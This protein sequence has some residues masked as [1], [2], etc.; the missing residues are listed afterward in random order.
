MRSSGDF[1]Y[2]NQDSLEPDVLADRAAEP[3]LGLEEFG[4][5]IKEG[6]VSKRIIEDRMS[7]IRSGVNRTPGVVY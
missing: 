3:G 2:E 6:E 5:A 1:N 7:G 4:S